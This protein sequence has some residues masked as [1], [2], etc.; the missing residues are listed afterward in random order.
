MA[1]EFRHY[2][3]LDEQLKKHVDDKTRKEILENMDYVR[4]SSKQEIKATWAY[5]VTKR[6]DEKIDKETCIKIREGCACV[7]SNE[8]SIYAKE[9]KKL[10]K[11]HKNDDEYLNEVIKYLN[12]TKP[13]RRCG[14][15][16]RD[17]DKIISIIGRGKCGCTV[18]R[19]GLNQPISK[20]W[21]QCCKGSLLSVYKYVYN[22][23]ECEMDILRT[24]ASG[25]SD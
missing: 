10:R 12:N 4:D 14:E 20:T 2:R 13:L 5:E 11:I 17:E 1:K 8:K 16:S 15:V 19:E 21:C 25:E 6:L 9:F 23:K 24:V 18:V 22:D 7:L 3:V